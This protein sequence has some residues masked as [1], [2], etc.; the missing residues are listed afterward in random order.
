MAHNVNNV[1]YVHMANPQPAP[2]QGQTYQLPPNSLA[3]HIAMGR[4]N[5]GGRSTT[6]HRLNIGFL[7]DN[8]GKAQYNAWRNIVKDLMIARNFVPGTTPM[9]YPDADFQPI[10]AGMRRLR[11]VSDQLATVSAAN[12]SQPM[13]DIDK[14]VVHLVKDCARKLFNTW[15]TH[16][17]APPQGQPGVPFA[18]GIVPGVL[19]STNNL[20]QWD[21]ATAVPN[22]AQAPALPAINQAQAPAPPAINQAQAPAP[23]LQSSLPRVILAAGNGSF[24]N[25]HFWLA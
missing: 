12:V 25:D 10:F 6:D 3:G 19:L 14:A 9:N 15:M 13:Q 20:A 7:I 22:V 17:R 5:P 11:P 1:Q 2:P 21:L 18:Q 4:S 24:P 23:L 8:P 16:P